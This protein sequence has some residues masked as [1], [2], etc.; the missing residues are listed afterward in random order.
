M[1]SIQL[2]SNEV[3]NQIAAG[4]VVERPAHLVKELVENSIDAGATEVTVDVKEGGRAISVQD[5]G[6]GLSAKDL[7]LALH[8]HTT[9]KIAMIDD[10]WKL[11]TFGFRGEALASIASVSKFQMLSRQPSEEKGA[12]LM[13]EFGVQAPLEFVNAPAGTSV[14]VQALFENVPARLK[15][16]KSQS[17]EV[18]ATK[19]V[20]KALALAHPK[21]A[22]RYRVEGELKF[23]FSSVDDRQSRSKQV[24]NVEVL[25]FAKG[26]DQGMDVEIVFA[27]ASVRARTS[28][29]IW[30]FVQNRW[31]QDRGIQAAVME[32]FRGTLMHGEYPIASVWLNLP[33]DEVDVNV[34]P[35]KSQVKFV[36]QSRVFKL[37]HRSLRRKLEEIERP[38]AAASGLS[39]DSQ[40]AQD[41]PL[42]PSI[43]GK[44]APFQFSASEFQQ[45]QY[46]KRP[47]FA[48]FRA[49]NS[50][51]TQ[52]QARVQTEA[53]A[54][55]QTE[56]VFSGKFEHEHERGHEAVGQVPGA[57]SSYQ[58]L[59]QAHLTYIVAQNTSEM[60][61][62]DQHA[63]H[64]R[65]LF[66]T[67][68]AAWS[69]GEIPQQRHLFPMVVQLTPEQVEA[70]LSQA[71]QL[72]RLG[73]GLESMGPTS[74]GVNATP[75][76]LRESCLPGVLEQIANE[77][78][79]RGGSFAF[80]KKL[81]DI[82]ATMACHSAIR[83]GQSLSLDEMRSLLVQMDQ[84]PFSSYCPHGRP[85]SVTWT[86]HEIEREFGRRG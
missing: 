11:R 76:F 66:E 5:N 63:A 4:E 50:G 18:G 53:R 79:E 65:V 68:S 61:F 32:A 12:M 62:I 73:I 27:D 34:H 20:I 26:S 82:L 36:D 39:V 30:I 35:T 19:Q 72:E 8:R 81:H 84:H 60:A 56:A 24:L 57:W 28:R 22:F 1:E 31:V 86:L 16:L 48:E 78:I 13:S 40:N 15:F 80:E 71:D 6:R 46:P 64:E 23:F 75:E 52:V 51:Q 42:S 3:I 74:V 41:V 54:Q 55:A 17:A 37:V 25:H 69:N 49:S 45:T 38:T 2:L 44:P 58:V 9:S 47:S 77:V 14:H 43:E 83:A 29:D 7:P 59:A 33:A 85:V 10:L 67:L 21:V 70:L